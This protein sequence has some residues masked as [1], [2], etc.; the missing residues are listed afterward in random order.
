MRFEVI[1]SV[2]I[3][4][5]VFSAVMVFWRNILPP[6]ISAEDAVCTSEMLVSTYKSTWC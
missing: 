2:K 1:T 5:L 3:L 4:M 6:T